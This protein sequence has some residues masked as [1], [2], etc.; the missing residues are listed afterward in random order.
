MG[1]DGSVSFGTGNPYQSVGS[2]FTSPE[3][4][5]YSNSVVNLDAAT[6]KLR[7]YYQGVPDDFK[8]YDLQASP[9]LASVKGAPVIVGGGKMGIV[10][11]MNARTG[12][13]IWKTPVGVHNGHDDDSLRALDHESTPNFPTP[14]NRGPRWGP[15]QHGVDGDTVYVATCNVAFKEATSSAVIGSPGAH[16]ASSATWRRST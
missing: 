1:P 16:P 11:E 15:H 10:Y 5:L 6:G 7:W 4:L 13:L 14:T 2:A 8:D 9:I 3:R 12:H